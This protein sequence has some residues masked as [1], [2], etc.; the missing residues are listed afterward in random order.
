MRSTF[1]P[2]RRNR[3]IGTSKQGHGQLNRLVVPDVAIAGE[4]CTALLNGAQVHRPIINGRRISLIVEENSGGCI[5]ACTA[6]DVQVLLSHVPLSDWEGIALFVLRQPTRKI[7]GLNPAW[8]RMYYYADVRI[9]GSREAFT[10][11]A[12]F[13]EATLPEARLTWSTSLDRE[14]AEEL[15]R[16]RLDGHEVER[17]GRRHVVSTNPEATRKTQLY[18]TLLHEIGHWVDWLEKVER[19]AE[20]MDFSILSERYF[21]RP[22][23]EREAFAHRYAACLRKRLEEDRV[24]PFPKIMG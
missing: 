4:R 14:D 17:S 8:G 12:I 22:K 16:L 6:E 18:R 5:H 23:S 1:N 3:N 21:A 24:I 11:P 15:D 7:R 20:Q 13:L 10:G 19:P 9:R 2:I